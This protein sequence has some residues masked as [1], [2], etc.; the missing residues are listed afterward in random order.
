VN[1]HCVHVTEASKILLDYS[2]CTQVINHS[3][4]TILDD[5]GLQESLLPL[6]TWRDWRVENSGR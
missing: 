3:R 6:C 2:G 4:G 1:N 5:L